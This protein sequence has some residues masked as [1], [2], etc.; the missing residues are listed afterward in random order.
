MTFS[1]YFRKILS[2][3]LECSV[4]GEDPHQQEV[5]SNTSDQDRLGLKQVLSS[6]EL[7]NRF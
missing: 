2:V 6:Y 5:A 1:Y 4:E 7:Q 3:F